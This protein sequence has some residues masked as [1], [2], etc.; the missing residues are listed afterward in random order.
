MITV[1]IQYRKTQGTEGKQREA[2]ERYQHA[3]GCN[4]KRFIAK[5]LLAIFL[6]IMVCTRPTRATICSSIMHPAIHADGCNNKRFNSKIFL[7]LFLE[8]MVCT[9]PT[10]ATMC[11]SIMHPAILPGTSTRYL[12]VCNNPVAISRIMTQGAGFTLHDAMMHPV[13]HASHEGRA[14]LV[15]VPGTRYQLLHSYRYPGT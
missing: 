6:E 5:T 11:S 8:I 9:R 3:D 10:R 4:N 1:L 15:G 7:A 12:V 2:T 13:T 14:Y